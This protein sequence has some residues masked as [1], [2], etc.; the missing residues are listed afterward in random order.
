MRPELYFDKIKMMKEYFS[1]SKN[2]K[3]KINEKIKKSLLEQKEVVFAF[4]FGSFLNSPSFRD[5]DIGVYA[6]NINKEK[7]FDYELGL[8]KKI[9]EALNLPF[10]II[11][12]KIL[13]FAPSSFLNN[14]FKNGELLFSK[15]DQI[16]S[17][18]IEKTSLDALANAHISYQS[19][20]ELVP[21]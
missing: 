3:Q 17:D 20:K 18:L 15:D 13:N 5:V 6:K 10:S 14:I 4:V 9:S 7:F 12:I 19:L 21:A 8:S 2:E 1:L 11:E 16:L